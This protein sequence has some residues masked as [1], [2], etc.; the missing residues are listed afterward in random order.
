MPINLLQVWVKQTSGS[1]NPLAALN[2][3]SLQRAPLVLHF[4]TLQAYQ[5]KKPSAQSIY[6]LLLKALVTLV[7]NCGIHSK[8]TGWT[9]KNSGEELLN[10]LGQ[11]LHC[12]SLC[13]ES[14]PHGKSVWILTWC[15]VHT[16][17]AFCFLADQSCLVA[18]V[19]ARSL[20]LCKIQN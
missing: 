9:G 15:I 6:A 7:S 14:V 2:R 18:S 4:W 16:L 12:V 20:S 8:K 11:A 1:N 10:H 3:E 19:W 5:Q 13:L 17:E